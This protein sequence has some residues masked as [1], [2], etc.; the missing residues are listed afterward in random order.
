MSAAI[1]ASQYVTVNPGVI[2]AAGIA[3]Y[4]NGLVLSASTRVPIGSGVIFT[5]QAAVASY[6]GPTSDEA[7]FAATYFSGFDNSTKKPNQLIIYQYP[8]AAVVAYLRGGPVTL[9]LTQIQAITPGTLTITINGQAVTSGTITL[10]SATSPSNVA[11]LIQTAIG[12]FDAVGTASITTTTMTV[13]AIASG[14]YAVGQVISGSG[15]TA[16]TKITAILTGTGGVGTYTVDTSQTASSTTISA[17]PTTVAYDSQSQAY[18]ISGGTPGTGTI[19]FA[20]GSTIVNKL[21]LN[22][23][24]GAVISQGA[25]ITDP[26]TAMTAVVAQTQNWATF[27]TLFK[28][29]IANMVLFASWTATQNNRFAYVMWDTDTTVTLPNPTTSAGYLIQQAGY[30]GTVPFYQ[31]TGLNP[32]DACAGA[33]VMG[34]V[35]S[36]DFARKN[37]RATLA[38]KGQSGFVPGVTDGP[39]ASQLEL[40]GYNYYGAVATAAQGFQYFYPGTVTGKFLWCDSYFGQINLNNDLQSANMTL[41]TTVNSIPYNDDGYGLIAAACQDPI[42]SAVNFGTIRQGVALTQLQKAEVN[43]AAG[44]KISDVLQTRGWYLIVADPGATVRAARGS[45]VIT[46]FYTDGGSVHRIVIA[47]IDVM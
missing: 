29:S 24:G 11:S 33:L 27:S 18:I 2:Q 44:L 45:P 20:S 46:L 32:V 7:Y 43:N 16:G 30:G 5:S 14:T 47:S 13:T 9:T 10:S 26:V 3:A 6:F 12:H 39:T 8:T 21:N 41:L 28:P 31:P 40:N 35:A 22:Q 25:P 19:T 15:V 1:P 17:G 34:Y 36:L 38:F 4:E 42:N 23:V 37:G